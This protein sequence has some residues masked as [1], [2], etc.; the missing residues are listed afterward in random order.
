MIDLVPSRANPNIL[1]ATEGLRKI[2]RT[3][4]A[5]SNTPTWVDVWSGL[6]FVNVSITAVETHPTDE[7]IVYCAFNKTIWRSS[8]KGATWEDI[9][10][11]LPEVQTN[12]IVYD[13][14]TDEGLYLG[15]DM[16]IYYK[17]NSMSEWI[18]FSDGMPLSVRVTELEIYYGESLADSR[19]RA[20]TYGRGLWESD[21]F[22]SETYNFPATAFFVQNTY[23]DEVFDDF[24]LDIRFYKNLQ[25][26]DVSGFTVD[27][28]Y[29]ENGTAS[30]VEQS[31]DLYTL[32]IEVDAFGPIYIYVENQ[33]ATDGFGVGTFH[34]DTL[35][36]VYNPEPEPFGIY[37][38][39]GVGDDSTIPMWL[40]ADK[41]ASSNGQDAQSEEPVDFWNNQGSGPD[42]EQA[43]DDE[44]PVMK[45]GVDGINNMPVV[46]FDG[47]NDFL[48]A[49]EVV[50]GQNISVFSVVEG[51]NI[52]F[53][54]HGWI[55]SA[56]QPNGFVLHPWKDE[57]RFSAMIID[58]DDDYANGPIYY[59][60]DAAAPHI[61]GVIYE[62][63]DYFQI[64]NTLFDQERY[65]F[66]GA[67][68]G[69]RD[70]SAQIDIRYGWDYDDRYGEG[71]LGEHFIYNRRLHQS[72]WIIVS[73]YLGAKYGIDLGLVKR[74][75]HWNKPF[76][77][78]GIG[79]ESQFDYHLDAQGTGIVRMS[80]PS[81]A[82]N[83]E[84]LLWGHD[85]E[86]YGWEEDGYPIYSQR[87]V[88]TWGYEQTGDLGE[89]EVRILASAIP[90]PGTDIGLIIGD[91]DEFLPGQSLD[92]I[93]LTLV[94]DYYTA[95]ASFPASG[96]FTIGVEPAV[97]VE[98]LSKADV[99]I[100]PNPSTD[101]FRIDVFNTT[102]SAFTYQ[103]FD[104][105]GRVVREG[106]FIGSTLILDGG[107]LAAGT[108]QLRLTNGDQTTAKTIVKF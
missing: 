48:E 70:G 90:D 39:G 12:S 14:N 65:E 64:F 102:L 5:N 81:A 19:M 56:R 92:Y 21:L 69:V 23:D 20:A 103:L 33:A 98:D 8:D 96:V 78:A 47:D 73:N 29:I 108:Y 62:Q 101:N 94:G 15:T 52:A 10:G 54:T 79:R 50:T 68:I 61:Y 84:Y 38:P 106:K 11:D 59:I 85:G 77:V 37:G 105:M 13:V 40:R 34:S 74:Y 28:V 25:T 104:Q 18:P 3:D 63:N 30:L 9:G 76:D 41:G 16:G 4:S 2:F 26:V 31:A 72:Q 107:Q 91:E 44:A 71:K 57:S 86:A 93:P 88:T 53:N 75:E 32:S 35:T 46:Y 60:G 1:Y 66:N 24:E 51:N 36:I 43:I 58:N 89:V 27:D 100:Y 42:A 80:N 87:L 7:N 83:E 45:T 97:G 49:N 67:D 82:S 95:T 55:A 22:D 99:R 6:P 17:D